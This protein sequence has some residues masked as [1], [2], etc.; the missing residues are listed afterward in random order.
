MKTT[1]AII[2]T[3]LLGLM[4]NAHANT[5]LRGANPELKNIA[6]CTAYI[7]LTECKSSML[8]MLLFELMH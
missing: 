3:I 2:S 5:S 6:S 7:A 1:S 8:D 4:A